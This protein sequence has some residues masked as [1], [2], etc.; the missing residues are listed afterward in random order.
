MIGVIIRMVRMY[1]MCGF[2]LI[3]W[4]SGW[5]L[6]IVLCCLIIVVRYCMLSV[7]ILLMNICSCCM[8]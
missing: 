8:L 2:L 5:W 3:G 7:C 4:S 6:M 1:F